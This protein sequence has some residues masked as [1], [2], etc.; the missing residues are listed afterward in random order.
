MPKKTRKEKIIAQYRKQLQMIKSQ[1]LADVNTIDVKPKKKENS[2]KIEITNHEDL[3][4]INPYFYRDLRK[5][6]LLI[7]FILVVE[8]GLFFSRLIK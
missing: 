5:S 4:V 6:I 3:P 1:T 7:I 2:S 8:T